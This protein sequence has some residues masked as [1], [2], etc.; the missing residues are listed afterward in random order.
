MTKKSQKKTVLIIEDDA[1]VQSFASRVLELQGYRVLQ[2]EDGDKGIRLAKENNVALVLLDLR[3]P[4]RDGWAMLAEMRSKPE[5]S[6]VPVVV[7]T[8]SAGPVQRDR[9]F[10][11]GAAGYPSKLLSVGSLVETVS[12]IIP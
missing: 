10:S 2:A 9:A 11:V 8:V 12:R 5:L 7:F 6:T 3:L 4:S 1:D